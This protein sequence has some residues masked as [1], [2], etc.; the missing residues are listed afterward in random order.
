MEVLDSVVDVL[1]FFLHELRA[2]YSEGSEEATN[3][4]AFFGSL[5]MGRKIMNK[6]FISGFSV[7]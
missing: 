1:Y 5:T 3:D 4:H 6:I 2:A 7:Y